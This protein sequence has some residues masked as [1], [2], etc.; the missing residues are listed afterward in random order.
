MKQ[1]LLRGQHPPLNA[2]NFLLLNTTDRQEIM[3]LIS[4]YSYTYDEAKS[5]DAW[6]SLFIENAIRSIYESNSPVP[7]MLTKSNEERRQEIKQRLMMR[8]TL[9]I[10][11]R[12]Y[13]TNT[14][15][16]K[17]SEGRAEGITMFW[18]LA[19]YV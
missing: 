10:Q 1:Q 3:D 8:A 16:N 15:L 2:M 4:R 11:T 14:L 7:M 9:G 13:M 5:P 18:L 19:E 17:T 6:V 12:H